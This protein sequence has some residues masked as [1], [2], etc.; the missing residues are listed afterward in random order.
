MEPRANHQFDPFDPKND[1]YDGDNDALESIDWNDPAS[2]MAAMGGPIPVC[3]SPIEVRQ[4]ATKR[5]RNIFA[6]YE[7]LSK[8]LER[9]EGTVQKRWT[10]KTRRQRLQILLKAWPDMPTPHRP[11]F[12]AFVKESPQ[13]REA[14]TRH[15]DSFMWPDINQEDLSQTKPL[16]LLL[17]ARGHN[18]PCAFAGADNLSMHLGHVTKAVVPIFLNGHTMVLNGADSAEE[19][20]QLLAWDD[21]EDA[22]TWMHTRKQYLPG[23]GLLVLQAQE[24][25]LVFLVECCQ[26]LLHD[27][28]VDDLTSDAFPLQPVPPIKSESDSLGFESLA[29]MAAEAPY[30]L[31]AQLDLARIESLLGARASAAEDHLWALR[32][33]PSYFAQQLLETRDHRQEMLKDTFGRPHPATGRG[34]ETILWARVVGNVLADA[35]LALL[36][37]SE[38]HRQ[39]QKLQLLQKKYSTTISPSKDLPQDYLLALLKFRHY[40]NQGAKGPFNVLKVAVVASPPMRKFYVREPN[41]DVHSTKIAVRSKTGQKMSKVE[42]RL[43][44]LLRTLWE[45]GTDLLFAG[46]PLVVDELERLLRAEPPVQELVSGHI[47]R[48]IGDVSIISQCLRQLDIY[49][50][51]AQNFENAAVEWQDDIEN[52]FAQRTKPWG[53]VLTALSDRNMTLVARLAEPSAGKFT[54]PISKRRTRENVEAL[55]QAELNLDKVWVQIDRAMHA[56]GI[57]L[58]GTSLQRLLSQPRILYRTPEWTEPTVVKGKEEQ[59]PDLDS[60]ALQMPFSAIFSGLSLGETTSVPVSAIQ[61]KVKVKT[62]GTASKPQINYADASEANQPGPRDTQPGFLVDS[63]ALKVFRA[64]FFD[65]TVTSTPGEVPWNDF[66]HAMISTG[67]KAEKLY[68]SVW[69]FSPTNLDVERSI[70]FHEPHPKGKLPF[71]VARRYG[72]RLNRAY[73]WFGGMFVL[74]DR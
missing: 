31:P 12:E 61:P 25:L 56:A 58:R 4:E 26:E 11:D 35:H 65:P 41:D 39:A 57:N 54:Y 24:R 2:F 32:E 51:W 48:V 15:A 53:G 27:I 7:T 3:L 74:K 71:E 33:D 62:R 44:W 40:L 30:R 38:L 14:A 49:Q 37:F 34:R 67:F 72:R 43:T 69:Q 10:K 45:D 59:V 28:P 68:G 18:P 19:Y 1:K 55:R 22:F 13:Q 50:P 23:E 9:H 73:G 20:G 8:I 21:H 64:L 17:N 47:V 63:R 52:E 5:S 36:L 60:A 29:V 46:L 66:L 42:G 16:L 6:T 70:H